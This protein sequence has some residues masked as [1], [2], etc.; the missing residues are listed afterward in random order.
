MASEAITTTN[1]DAIRIWTADRG[2]V[3]A[4]VESTMKESDVG[5]LR[6]FFPGQGS[7]DELK[8]IS[9]DEFFSKFEEEKLAFVCDLHT[10]D[11]KLSRFS[12]LI[13]RS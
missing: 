9:W 11:G 6:I 4:A 3:P 2:G 7:G 1:H 8:E 13:T 5:L 12:K 10:E